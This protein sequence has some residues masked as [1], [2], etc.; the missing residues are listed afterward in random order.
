MDDVTAKV[1]ANDLKEVETLREE[2][3]CDVEKQK[4]EEL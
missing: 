1:D 4:D 3:K 2:K